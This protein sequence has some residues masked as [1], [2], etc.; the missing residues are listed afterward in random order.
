[1]V[2][3]PWVSFSYSP[4]SF[5]LFPSM[6]HLSITTPLNEDG[7]P[8]ILGRLETATLVITSMYRWD[9]QLG[10]SEFYSF[11]CAFINLLILFI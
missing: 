7:I 9:G 1:M 4:D 3:T 2:S 8:W 6:I 10:L 5:S 11:L